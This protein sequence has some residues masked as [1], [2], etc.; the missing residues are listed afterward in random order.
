MYQRYAAPALVHPRGVAQQ[1]EPA[2]PP[3]IHSFIDID[4]T[5]KGSINGIFNSVS[6]SFLIEWVAF[7]TMSSLI[8][9]LPLQLT[10]RVY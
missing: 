9:G 1:P 10:V 6:F 7:F 8:W 2:D 5:N 3:L 4:E